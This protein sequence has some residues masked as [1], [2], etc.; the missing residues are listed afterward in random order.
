MTA[1]FH[2]TAGI[3]RIRDGMKFAVALSMR[4]PRRRFGNGG[5]KDLAA[6][7]HC[8][9]EGLERGSQGAADCHPLEAMREQ[10]LIESS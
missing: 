1:E 5:F 4:G 6:D 9:D 7:Y 10:A 8:N 2:I 3:V